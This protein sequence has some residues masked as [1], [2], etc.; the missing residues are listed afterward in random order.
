[1]LKKKLLSKFKG[2][3]FG[4]A[5]GDALGAPVEG[6]SADE[7]KT[8]YGIIR[9]FLDERFGSGNWTDDTQMA[10]DIAESY[11]DKKECNIRDISRRFVEWFEGGG[12]GIGFTTSKVLR[13]IS[14]GLLPKAA[15]RL[16]WEES[17]QELA[18]NGA[19]MRCA[20]TALVRFDDQKRRSFETSEISLITHFDPRSTE[21][22]MFFNDLLADLVV[23]KI[24]DIDQYL[25]DT[26]DQRVIDTVMNALKMDEKKLSCGGYVLDTLGVS[27][28]A[29]RNI[30][31]FEEALVRVVNLGGDTDTNAA[32]A[33]ALFG[34]KYGFEAIPQR[35]LGNL[36]A[37]ER[38][39]NTAVKLLEIFHPQYE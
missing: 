2:C 30:N 18:G 14:Q 27:V 38:I 5:I 17:H 19:L 6:K 11:I 4:I 1:M 3:M 25:V 32:V 12:R 39:E 36:N 26:G 8:K 34:A 13:H 22:C 29:Y 20:P 28:W 33:G 23:D 7:I 16:V 15:S 10:L 31:N 35:W 24:K 21:S 37:Y 9:D